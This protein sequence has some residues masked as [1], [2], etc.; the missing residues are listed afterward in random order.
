LRRKSSSP[1]S[2]SD[3][4]TL[5]FVFT[6]FMEPERPNEGDLFSGD[7][8]RSSFGTERE[9]AASGSTPKKASTLPQ[10][11][12]RPPKGKYWHAGRGE[13]LSGEGPKFVGRPR[14]RSPKGMK[15]NPITGTWVSNE[16][17][18]KQAL[19]KAYSVAEAQAQELEFRRLAAL[20]RVKAVLE[21][22]TANSRRDDADPDASTFLL[23][24]VASEAAAAAVAVS[25]SAMPAMA[26]IQSNGSDLTVKAAQAA[27]ATVSGKKRP[28]EG[29]DLKDAAELLDRELLTKTE[30]E[31][32]KAKILKRD[33]GQGDADNVDVLNELRTLKGEIQELRRRVGAFE[34]M[35]AKEAGLAVAPQSTDAAAASAEAKDTN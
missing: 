26:A 32:I 2:L 1:E 24:T 3:F 23:D 18:V 10:P 25:K 4:S 14:G 30:F 28:R 27:L 16:D 20:G 7:G 9:I 22:Q 15:W 5:H 19:A 17:E 8:A 21:T 31:E 12:G 13:W 35:R 11:R 34:A 29:L 6:A 33:Y